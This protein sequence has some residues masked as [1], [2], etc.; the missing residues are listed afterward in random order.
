MLSGI[1]RLN[2][3]HVISVVNHVDCGHL[4]HHDLHWLPIQGCFSIMKCSFNMFKD[5]SD[6]KIVLPN[7]SNCASR[8]HVLA[9]LTSTSQSRACRTTWHFRLPRAHKILNVFRNWGQARYQPVFWSKLVQHCQTI[10]GTGLTIQ[11]YSVI[12]NQRQ[13]LQQ[14]N[15]NN[16]N[17]NNNN[18]N[19]I[20]Q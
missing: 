5:S 2:S 7:K 12:T 10:F 14:Y 13:Q 19:Q 6:S 9:L 16:N 15:N 18:K 17:N 4:S 1:Q 20:I 11:L 3:I 8:I